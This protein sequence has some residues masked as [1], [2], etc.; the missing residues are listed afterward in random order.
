M[1]VGGVWVD[2]SSGQ[3]Y[4]TEDP[5][6]GVE[7]CEVPSGGVNDVEQAVK[8]ARDAAE[9]GPW[10]RMTPSQ[11]EQLLFKFTA[12][13]EVH[14]DELAAIESLDNGKPVRFSSTVDVPACIGHFRYF[15]GWPTK[16]RG[17]TIPVSAIECLNYTVREP[18]GVV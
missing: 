9:D 7:I 14:A 18:I 17:E 15:S 6:T 12:L 10:A 3:T 2:A 11:R 1:L 8:A 16:I 5:S 13:V 4:A